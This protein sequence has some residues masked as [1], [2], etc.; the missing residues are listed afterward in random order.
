[1]NQPFVVNNAIRRTESNTP[2]V[3]HT[4]CH[5]HLLSNTPSVTH[6]FY[7]KQK[8]NRFSLRFRKNTKCFNIC[9][10]K[11]C[12]DFS[13]SCKIACRW[14]M[15]NCCFV[16]DIAL[17]RADSLNKSAIRQFRKFTFLIPRHLHIVPRHAMWHN[18]NL[19]LRFE[20]KDQATQWLTVTILQPRLIQILRFSGTDFN[21]YMTISDIL[22]NKLCTISM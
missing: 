17:S 4:F 2:S 21:H 6:T 5:T 16:S 1:M 14:V 20:E 18:S 3:T 11:F 8:E 15:T 13:V 12:Q 22:S 7:P 19:R 10:S 9:L